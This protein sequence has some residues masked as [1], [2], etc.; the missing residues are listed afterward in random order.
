MFDNPSTVAPRLRA[1]DPHLHR[2]WQEVHKNYG[3]LQARATAVAVEGREGVDDLALSTQSAHR[4][5]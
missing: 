3:F 4:W 1:V 5:R 2:A